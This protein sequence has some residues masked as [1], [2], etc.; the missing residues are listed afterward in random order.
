MQMVNAQQDRIDQCLG[1]LTD[2]LQPVL[3]PDQQPQ[4]PT[5]GENAPQEAQLYAAAQLAHD[6]AMFFADQLERLCQ[7][8]NLA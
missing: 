8:I 5:A 4:T 7:R 3:L 2:K 1:L 6:R